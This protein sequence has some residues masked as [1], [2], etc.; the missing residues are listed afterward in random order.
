MSFQVQEFMHRLQ[1]G[2]LARVLRGLFVLLVAGAVAALYDNLAFRNLAQR[3][4]MDMAQLG[5]NLAEGQGYHTLVVRPLSMFLLQ[6]HRPDRSPEIMG[7]HPDLANPPV[8]PALLAGLF[9]LLPERWFKASATDF[10]IYAPDLAIALLNQGLL[11]SA[12]L[13]LWFLASRLFDPFIGWVSSIVF[14]GTELF[15][16]YSI[17]GLN[18][19]LLINIFLL[20]VWVLVILEHWVRVDRPQTL[21]VV[22]AGV[23]GALVGL[24]GLTRYSFAWL[25][26]PVLV[27]L[28]WFPGQK[29][30]LFILACV[31]VFAVM[32]L[33]WVART[34]AL[35]GLPFGT[36]TLTVCENTLPFPGD[37][38]QRSLEPDLRRVTL[39]DLGRKG[40]E[41]CRMLVRSDLP[42]LGGN[43]ISAFFLAGL[44]VPFRNK[45]LSRL[46]WFVL[47]T[48][49]TLGLTQ[50]MVR[51]V[52]SLES[53]DVD[54]GN[55]LVLAAPLVFVFGV[56]FFFTLL[57]SVPM[58]FFAARPVCAGLLCVVTSL[59]L[60]FELLPPG[61]SPVAYP[62]YYPPLI[63]KV[64]SWFDR[65]ELIMSDVPWATAWYGRR[66]S[67]LATL[68]WDKDF[69]EINDF[70]KTIK[71][72][73]LT[74]RTTDT[75]FLSDWV[76]GDNRGWAS[77]LLGSLL[78]RQ[79]PS[80]FP[81]RRAPAGF[82]P[83]QLVLTDYERWK[84]R[85]D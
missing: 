7:R 85:G 13:L 63:Q 17:S 18:T 76:R 67:L 28:A 69:M 34:Q 55:M 65:E 42:R 77:F 11:L 38:L 5:K 68:T 48:L 6:R 12:A 20:L 16:R 44:L 36:A 29:R 30:A 33:P 9:R 72:I 64:G 52:D 43:W 45:R 73:Y 60:I 80:G 3:E 61:M 23:C 51:T 10:G 8:Y 49:V 39:T 24:G 31:G 66:Q 32:L 54:P 53:P 50:T 83:E 78:D 57:D 22:L 79:V 74:P 56:A 75:K 15:W 40:L 19:L 71:G 25:I 1:S 70:Q 84:V 14:V 81:L 82:F 26:I 21:Q 27:F 35:C 4:A 46:R 2:G 37:R 62:P 47:L 41:G 59:P 58:A